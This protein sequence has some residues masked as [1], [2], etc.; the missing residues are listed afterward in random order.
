M[1]GRKGKFWGDSEKQCWSWGNVRR[2]QLI[3]GVVEY[4]I[5]ALLQIRLSLSVKEFWKS[6]NIWR[7]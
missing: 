1:I 4:F 5:I 3:W 7:H 2:Q 6:V